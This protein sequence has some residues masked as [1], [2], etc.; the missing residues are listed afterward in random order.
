MNM[1][2]VSFDSLPS[3]DLPFRYF[4]SSAIFIIFVALLVLYSGESVWLTRWH[5]VMLAI[6]HGFTLGFIS[7]VMMGALLQIFPVVGGRGFPKV[8]IIA[9]S[10][11]VKHGI[12]IPVFSVSTKYDVGEAGIMEFVA[13]TVGEHRFI[14]NVF[15]GSGH[16]RM[17]GKKFWYLSKI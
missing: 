14:C 12:V 1:S 11:D 3:I 2:G 5:P 13:D 8:K 6:T 10:I 17:D 4:I 16:G 15:C 7:S 9:T